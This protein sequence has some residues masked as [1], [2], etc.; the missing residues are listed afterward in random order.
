[1]KSFLEIH[2]TIF[3]SKHHLGSIARYGKRET[4]HFI[5]AEVSVLIIK[6]SH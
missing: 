6:L 2:L 3:V 1:M 5:V 4:N